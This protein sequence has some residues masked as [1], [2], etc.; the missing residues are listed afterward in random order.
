[1]AAFGILTWKGCL[2]TMSKPAWVCT[3]YVEVPFEDKGRYEAAILF[4]VFHAKKH[5]TQVMQMRLMEIQRFKLS[6]SVS[7]LR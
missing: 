7:H 2:D 4:I 6:H 3:R 5:N 1:M